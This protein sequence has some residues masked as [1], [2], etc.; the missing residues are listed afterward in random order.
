MTA[1]GRAAR[2][3]LALDDVIELA[4]E[5]H[6]QI[7]RFA[8]LAAGHGELALAEVCPA[9]SDETIAD[10]DVVLHLTGPRSP[11]SSGAIASSARCRVAS[12]EPSASSANMS[13]HW[14]ANRRNVS[15]A[16][17]SCRSPSPGSA[18]TAMTPSAT[19][20]VAVPRSSPALDEP[21]VRG[22]QHL[23]RAVVVGP[24]ERHHAQHQPG[25]SAA[26]VGQPRPGR[27][28]AC[29]R[30]TCSSRPAGAGRH[31]CPGPTREPRFAQRHGSRRYPRRTAH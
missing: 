9:E 29:A 1:P 27:V 26:V 6:R 2:W 15:T 21:L 19:A 17:R 13:H 24:Q 12:V 30:R 3:T 4:A 14:S 5:R 11:S 16:S 31:G 22:R 20:A 28:P 18:G 23:R 10:Q 8:E 25:V 7:E